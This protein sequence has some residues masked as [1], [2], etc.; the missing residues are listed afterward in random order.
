MK[1]AKEIQYIRQYGKEMQAQLKLFLHTRDPTAL[2]QFRVRVK[3]LKSLLMLLQTAPGNRR[4]MHNFKPIKKVFGKAG[5]IREMYIHLQLSS[6]YQLHN[7]SSEEEQQ[8]LQTFRTEAFC[9][10][11]HKHLKNIKKACKKITGHIHNISKRK[12]R[13]FYKDH[14]NSIALF[15]AN[16]VF[17][18]RLHDCRKQMKF[19]LHNEKP[20]RKACSDLP[21]LNTSYLDELQ[22]EI[23]QWHD[24]LLAIELFA[25]PQAG[26]EAVTEKIRTGNQELQNKIRTTAAGFPE[27]VSSLPRHPS[28]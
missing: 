18:D 23:G 6:H 5:A 22:E 9:R 7:G 13:Q 28:T 2:H 24:N 11:G 1:A 26:N 3:K 10:K 21:P 19:L 4:L 16:P 25:S 12:I 14:L 20:A 8:D 17:D 15:M 27:K